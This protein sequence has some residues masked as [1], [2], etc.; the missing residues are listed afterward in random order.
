ML[1]SG[2]CDVCGGGRWHTHIY[3][4]NCYTLNGMDVNICSSC[5]PADKIFEACRT[6][7]EVF[8]CSMFFLD[9]V[10]MRAGK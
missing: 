6:H 9:Y 3:I 1:D 8:S 5:V 7:S 2:R 4:S 10:K